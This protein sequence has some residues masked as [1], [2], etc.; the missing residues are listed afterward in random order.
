MTTDRRTAQAIDRHI[1][2]LTDD[3]WHANDKEPT[4]SCGD[5]SWSG[6]KDQLV[7]RKEYEPTDSGPGEFTVTCCPKCGSDWVGEDEPPEREEGPEE[8]EE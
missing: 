1:Q 7:E 4:W 6:E 2:G 8:E 5:C 3:Y